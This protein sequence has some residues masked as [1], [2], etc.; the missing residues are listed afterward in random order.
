MYKL[1][2]KEKEIKER[3]HSLK[4]MLIKKAKTK[5]IYENFGQNEVKK[6]IDT[7]SYNKAV[8][9]FDNWCMNFDQKQLNEV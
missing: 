8:E 5:G 2:S 3:I 4:L 6:L 7:F 9:D 1:I